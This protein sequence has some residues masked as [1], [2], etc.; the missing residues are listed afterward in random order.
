MLTFPRIAILVVCW[1]AGVICVLRTTFVSGKMLDEVN[2]KLPGSQ[3]LSLRGFD[4]SS[5]PD[6]VREYRRLYP[7]GPRLAQQ[8]SATIIT[9]LV[10]AVA[11]FA[12]DL[13]LAFAAI[14]G[15]GGSVARWF[16]HRDGRPPAEP[17]PIQAPP[18]KGPAT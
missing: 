2:G 9:V 10:A 18:P 17:P 13:G 11:F 5:Y 1:V 4:P 6:A 8:R 15:I 14:V 3:K 16:T 12:A 7:S